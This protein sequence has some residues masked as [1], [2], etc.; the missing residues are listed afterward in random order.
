MNLISASTT[1]S[2][3]TRHILDC[4]QLVPIISDYTHNKTVLDIGTGGGLPGIVLAIANPD[5]QFLLAEK[6]PKKCIFLES[7]INQLSLNNTYIY[8]DNIETIV[9]QNI[10]SYCI[11]SRAFRSLDYILNVVSKL[12]SDTTL[13]LL[14]GE[15]FQSEI[16]EAMQHFSFICVTK[17]SITKSEAAL[18]SISDV[19][20]LK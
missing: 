11:V 16:D 19:K 20:V 15:S 18:L 8:N 13:H 10:K 2:I 12:D 7:V 1:S 3:W 14:K 17:E 6:S 5:T 4:L 9:D